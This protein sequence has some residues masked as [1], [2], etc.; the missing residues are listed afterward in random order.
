MKPATRTTW[1]VILRKSE[2]QMLFLT[3]LEKIDSSIETTL[4]SL[5][6]RDMDNTFCIDLPIVYT[7]NAIPVQDKNIVDWTDRQMGSTYIYT[8]LIQRR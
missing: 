3:T 6:V 7:K 4:V 2:K 1:T 8:G 5:K